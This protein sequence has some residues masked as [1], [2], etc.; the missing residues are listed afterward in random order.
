MSFS[1]KL[2][3]TLPLACSPYL[4]YPKKPIVTYIDKMMDMP[5]FSTPVVPPKDAGVFMF[6]SSVNTWPRD[7]TN[8]NIIAFK[9]SIAGVFGTHTMLFYYYIFQIFL[10]LFIERDKAINF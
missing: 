5:V 6:F 2:S 10:N 3:V 1:G 7:T 9:Y 4:T 8:T